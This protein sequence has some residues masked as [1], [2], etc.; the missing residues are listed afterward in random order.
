MSVCILKSHKE[1]SSISSNLQKTVTS[2]GYL[3]NNRTEV[4]ITELHSAN[5]LAVLNPLIRQWGTHFPSVAYTQLTSPSP[6]CELPLKGKKETEAQN[7]DG[8][9]E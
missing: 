8:L 2:K 5:R 3:T 6:T 1:G 7:R 9:H 4:T